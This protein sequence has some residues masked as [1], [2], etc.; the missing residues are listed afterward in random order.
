[1]LHW[2]YSAVANSIVGIHAALSH[3]F[4][5]DSGWAWGLS[6]V[7]LVVAIRILLF[8]LFVKQIKT[9][10]AMAELQPKIKELQQKY[11]GDRETL[12]TE[13]MKLYRENNANPLGGCLPLLIQMPIFFALF[14]VLNSFKPDANGN[15]ESHYGISADLVESAAKA[16][17]FGAPIASAFRSSAETVHAL[18]ATVGVVKTVTVTMI[19]LMTATTFI[20]QRQLMARNAAQTS[21]TPMAQQ[22]KVLLYVLPFMFAIFGINFPVGVILYWVTTNLWTMGQQFLVLNR[23]NPAPGS[24]VAPPAGARAAV[25]PQPQPVVRQQPVRQRNRSNKKK[26]KGRRR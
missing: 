17:V 15:F 4:D 11:R 23:M 9:Q 16:K 1:M 21:G 10:R 18:G 5:P 6:I 7:L 12:N 24:P 20:T 25:P 22:Q 8:P 26:K 2:F 13:L 14:R 19:I 3:V